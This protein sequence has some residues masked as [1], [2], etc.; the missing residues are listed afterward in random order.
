MNVFLY[1]THIVTKDYSI[2]RE[3]YFQKTT[4]TT[5]T[6]MISAIAAIVAVLSSDRVFVVHVVF[7]CVIFQGRGAE[8]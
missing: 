1:T 7:F 2:C 5:I 8:L 6:K 4:T 3:L